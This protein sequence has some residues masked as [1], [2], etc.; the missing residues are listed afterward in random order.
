MGHMG[1]MC[2][3]VVSAAL[4]ALR[5]LLV[6]MGGVLMVFGGPLVMLCACFDIGTSL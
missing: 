3:R 2:R 4:V 6:V 5:R 1:V